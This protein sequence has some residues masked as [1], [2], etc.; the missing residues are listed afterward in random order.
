MSDSTNNSTQT[1]FCL[2]CSYVL[3][4]LQEHR[5]PEC[6]LEFDPDD[7]RTFAHCREPIHRG[8]VAVA[9]TLFG[10]FMPIFFVYVFISCTVGIPALKV[11]VWECLWQA[12]GP[13]G[14]MMYDPKA[15][16]GVVIGLTTF[17]WIAWLGV[18][19]LTPA[20]RLPYAIHFSSGFL[21]SLLGLPAVF[22][23]V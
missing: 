20:R 14:L 23:G 15:D 18:V 9:W 17:V 3:H 4:G 13:L 16:I 8:V 12:C 22:V 1:M 7:C 21:W 5:C 19:I 10:L 2:R 6:G 11:Y